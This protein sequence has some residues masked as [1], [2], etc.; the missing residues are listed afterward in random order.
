MSRED[1]V[2]NPETPFAHYEKCRG[3]YANV[4]SWFL[5]GTI[6]SLISLLLGIV[7]TVENAAG[8][9]VHAFMGFIF[10]LLTILG[11]QT[12]RAKLCFV[13]IPFGLGAAVAVFVSGS[14]IAVTG[15]IVYLAATFIAYRTIGAV[16]TFCKLR[17][18]PGFPI[19]DESL[20]DAPFAL[21]SEMGADE[22]IDESQIHEELEVQKYVPPVPESEEMDELLTEGVIP[23]EKAVG[24]YESETAEE[25]RDVPEDLRD[26]VA[27]SLGHLAPELSS[28]LMAD[29]D[30]VY[31]KMM[32]YKVNK[33]DEISD[34]D[35][36]G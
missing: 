25:L 6:F 28:E 23:H 1:I 29:D 15:G 22:F 10:S 4:K 35:L 36:F 33:S 8:I 16:A 27:V 20:E 9:A 30:Y 26:E 5:A 7:C 12:R 17:E 34:V 11:C 19:F 13:A 31:E 3:M 24:A 21:M 18:L 32:K 2:F 14:S